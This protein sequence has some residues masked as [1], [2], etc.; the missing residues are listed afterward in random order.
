[1]KNMILKIEMN[2]QIKSNVYAEK[3]YHFFSLNISAFFRHLFIMQLASYYSQLLYPYILKPI[4]LLHSFN[5]VN[6]SVV[7]LMI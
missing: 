4:A 7:D 3:A 6:I 1:M 5:S 2:Q